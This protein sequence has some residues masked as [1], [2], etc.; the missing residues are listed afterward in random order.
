MLYKYIFNI[1]H[2]FENI[3]FKETKFSPIISFSKYS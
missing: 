2:N 1:N 3:S